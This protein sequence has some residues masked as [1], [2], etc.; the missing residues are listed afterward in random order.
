MPLGTCPLKI[1]LN[2]TRVPL[3]PCLVLWSKPSPL[4]SP[5]SQSLLLWFHPMQNM[6]KNSLSSLKIYF[7]KSVVH[8]ITLSQIC[9]V[10]KNPLAEHA[11]FT[12]SFFSFL[13]L[14]MH[15]SS[16]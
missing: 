10:H 15:S 12:V 9:K 14:W 2:W 3:E 16:C 7:L 4:C 1:W 13:L 8:F 5:S 6:A 11:G